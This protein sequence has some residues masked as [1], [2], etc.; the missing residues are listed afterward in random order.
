[1]PLS[2]LIR[3]GTSTWAY[4]GWQGLVYRKAYP[5][6]RFKKDSLAEY[7]HFEYKGAP[8][9]RTVGLDATFYRPATDH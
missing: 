9:F 5:K 6:G 7:T 1:M 8:L 3:F 2:P 4:E